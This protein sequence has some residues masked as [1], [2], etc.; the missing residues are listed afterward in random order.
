MAV[1]LSRRL[2]AAAALCR[3]RARV[4]DVGCDHGKLCAYLL[5]NNWC[6][7]A[8]ATD[9][10][11]QPLHKARVLLN[12]LD[13]GDRVQLHCTDGLDGIALREGDVVVVA[14]VGAD[15]TAGILGRVARRAPSELPRDV[16]FVLVPA[17]H[18]ER[19][20][21][22]LW[23]NGFVLEGETAV[24]EA[25]HHYTVMHCRLDG[26]PRSYTPAEAACGL[27]RPDEGDGRAYLAHLQKRSQR[28]LDSPCDEDK[29]Q[30]ARE[31]LRRIEK[32]LSGEGS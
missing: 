18:H 25:G 22:W 12:E 13:L 21:A 27:V 19:V 4:V 5:A 1:T 17:S 31:T 6:R 20:R 10:H 26:T 32:I 16:R 29:K 8:V 24:S 15:V 7:E 11:S 23:D 30:T 9:I 2:M 14:G 3:G 28:L